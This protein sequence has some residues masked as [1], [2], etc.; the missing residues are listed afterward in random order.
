MNSNSTVTIRLTV[1]QAKLALKSVDDDIALFKNCLVSA[2]LSK[3]PE[4]QAEAVGLAQKVEDHV[5]VRAA[6][7][8][9]VHDQ[10]DVWL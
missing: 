6:I 4:Y 5:Q 10:H 3:N 8:R 1:A 9:A 7:V 2:T